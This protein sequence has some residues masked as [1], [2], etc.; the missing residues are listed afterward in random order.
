MDQAKKGSVPLD[1]IDL[2]HYLRSNQLNI[3][4]IF[5]T[6]QKGFISK[7]EFEISLKDAGFVPKDMSKL[8]QALDTKGT[9]ISVS[10]DKFNEYMKKLAP[11]GRT[12]TPQMARDRYQGF[13]PK[14]RQ[15]LQKICD[16]MKRNNISLMKM[17]EDMDVNKD[18]EVDK[19]EFVNALSYV[20]VPGVQL[21][22]L[23]M[24][25]DAIDI[26]NDGSLSINEFG[27]FIEGA[28]TCKMQ[29]LQDLDPK[30]I[31]DMKKEIHTLFQQFDDDGDGYVTPD[32][33][34]KAMMSLGQRISI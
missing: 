1:V 4:S 32:E 22:D 8:I 34:Y 19:Q 26:N 24:I 15:N 13:D 21:S 10:L 30:L 25:Y 27:M 20:Q 14:V 17:Y 3:Q 29:R 9:R 28:K 11:E 12:M 31:D 2:I 23:G 18:G 7:G 33:I 5:K 16:F 6:S